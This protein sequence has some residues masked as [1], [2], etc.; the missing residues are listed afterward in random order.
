M[1]V[2][3]HSFISKLPDDSDDLFYPTWIDNYYPNRPSDLENTHLYDFLAWYD[4][5]AK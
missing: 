3:E 1:L 2:K 4:L 5:V